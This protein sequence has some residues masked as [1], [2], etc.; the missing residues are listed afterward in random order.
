MTP[1]ERS[2]L[3]S[4]HQLAKENNQLLRTLNR[5]GRWGTIAKIFYWAIIIGLSFGAFYFIQPY[6][7]FVRNIGHDGSTK[8]QTSANGLQSNLEQIQDLLK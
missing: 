7:D 6:I 4:T 3:E 1:E 2:L 8:G 5:R